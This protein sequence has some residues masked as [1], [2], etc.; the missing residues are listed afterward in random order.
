[1]SGGVSLDASQPAERVLHEES[2]GIGG[3]SAQRTAE[4][5]H[6]RQSSLGLVGRVSNFWQ[7]LPG[8]REC[9]TSGQYM[10]VRCGL[11]LAPAS[12]ASI[13]T[14]CRRG[15]SLWQTVVDWI[16]NPRLLEPRRNL[17]PN[18]ILLLEER[19]ACARLVFGQCR[20]V[21]GPRLSA[22]LDRSLLT[23]VHGRVTREIRAEVLIVWNPVPIAVRAW[24]RRRAA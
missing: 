4:S 13:G 14:R 9:R 1:M 23:S 21:V 19:W 7:S 2:R 24:R 12:P 10:A 11:S 5:R 18:L 6:V 15:R 17:T 3:T 16:S 22:P 20:G 8:P